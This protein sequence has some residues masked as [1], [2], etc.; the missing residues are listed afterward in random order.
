VQGTAHED[1]GESATHRYFTILLMLP[2]RAPGV[3]EAHI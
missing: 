2:R 1:M 3:V